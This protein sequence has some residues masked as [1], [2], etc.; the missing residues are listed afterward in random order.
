[1]AKAKKNKTGLHDGHR[2]RM[3]ERFREHGIESFQPH[4]ILELLLFHSYRRGN[5]N[6]VAHALMD[7]FGSFHAV[8]EASEKE[9]MKVEGIGPI[10]AHLIRLIPAIHREYLQSQNEQTGDIYDRAEKVAK[11][12]KPY[13]LGSKN[14]KIYMV[15]L[16][17]S[18][19][20][21]K[22]LQLDEGSPGNVVLNMRKL[23][24]YP[25]Q[26]SA[27]SVI[28]AHNHPNAFSMPSNDDINSTAQA[29]DILRSLQIRL[30]DHII[31]DGRGD[32]TSLVNFDATRR[33]FR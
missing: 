4:E 12:L 28:L 22:C 23:A 30:R 33:R 2:E 17:N 31:F 21:I 13:F 25:L 6:E 26:Y 19:R 27:T 20:L 1:M 29:I 3:R 14:E 16:D 10:S 7:H 18:N 9:L 15:L 5:T 11:L 32:Y 8:F 24:E